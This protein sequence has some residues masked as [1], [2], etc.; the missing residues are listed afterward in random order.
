[1]QIDDFLRLGQ[2]SIETALYTCAPILVFGLIAG[3][4][5]SIFQAATQINDPALAFIP[6]I[7]AAVVGMLM[8]GHFMINRIAGFT[9]YVYTQIGTMSPH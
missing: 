4:F 5:V 2:I 3:L 6:K 7:G 9:T 1:M 8:F